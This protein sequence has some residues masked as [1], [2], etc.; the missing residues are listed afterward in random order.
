M[1]RRAGLARAVRGGVRAG[2]GE[3]ARRYAR[4]HAP[5]DV[6]TRSEACDS[7]LAA[8][9]RNAREE[10]IYTETMEKFCTWGEYHKMGHPSRGGAPPVAFRCG[11]EAI[12]CTYRAG[13]SFICIRPL[14][15]KSS[16]GRHFDA[17]SRVRPP[18]VRISIRGRQHNAAAPL[19]CRPHSLRHVSR[20]SSK[21][22][23]SFTTLMCSVDTSYASAKWLRVST[24][25]R[26]ERM[27]SRDITD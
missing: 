1:R 22:V 20:P 26:G 27:N 7:L 16:I 11:H 24:F 21:R 23:C 8:Q 10:F 18:K 6:V 2:Q 3:S 9:T 14:L 19:R 17:N 4:G 13:T 25:R 5:T 15:A 12:R